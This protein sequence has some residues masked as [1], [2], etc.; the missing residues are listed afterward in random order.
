MEGK[1]GLEFS[2]AGGGAC[3]PSG[4]SGGTAGGLQQGTGTFLSLPM[5]EVT[6][7]LLVSLPS[8]RGRAGTQTSRLRQNHDHLE[9]L[10]ER[11][12]LLSEGS[13]GR[14]GAEAWFVIPAL[15]RLRQTDYEYE[16]SLG[17]I[18][19]SRPIWATQ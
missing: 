16:A 5:K 13:G 6:S 17:Y 8:G 9:R 3:Q 7:G 12:G 18:M 4:L 15:Q 14:P 11:L 1:C 10:I 2:T 19:N